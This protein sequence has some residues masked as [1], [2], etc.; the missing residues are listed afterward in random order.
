[1]IGAVYFDWGHLG[2]PRF[3]NATGAKHAAPTGELIEA[4]EIPIY[5]CAAVRRCYDLGI[6]VQVD[7]AGSYLERQRR[8]VA[9]ANAYTGSVV[10]AA[11]HLNMFPGGPVGQRV[12]FFH[13]ARSANGA[14]LAAD[15]VG[16][17]SDVDYAD[18]IRAYPCKSNDWTKNA[19][20]CI[21]DIYTGPANVAGVTLE[22][23]G[24]NGT[25]EPTAELLIDVGHRIADGI[26]AYFG[27]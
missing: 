24:L 5:L 15:L 26:A 23:L 10:Y 4:H 25:P 17:F 21:R 6:F 8:A 3:P 12:G 1:M 13:D 27:A 16:A 11:A 14:K 22:P 2:Q 9:F 7:A 18:R 20:Y 19:L